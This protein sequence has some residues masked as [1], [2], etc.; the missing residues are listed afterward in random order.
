MLHPDKL[1]DDT[2]EYS[3]F[4][5]PGNL[6]LLALS[7]V[8]LF[9]LHVLA[10]LSWRDSQRAEYLADS[11]AARVGDTHAVLSMLEKS[12]LADTFRVTLQRATLNWENQDLFAE[13]R[14]SV[15]AVPARELERIRRIEQ[16]GN[17]RL[18]TSHPPTALR[19]KLLKAHPVAEPQVVIT[20]ADYDQIER[21]LAV[22]RERVQ[23]K[24]VNAYRRSL[25]Y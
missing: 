20:Q 7:T 19:V 16:K 23:E 14:K 2:S 11:L 4:T 24:L 1:V 15:A 22:A 10:N 8:A 18:D 9:W 21:E 12:H 6:I 25:Y 5:V 17:S 3:F 13:V